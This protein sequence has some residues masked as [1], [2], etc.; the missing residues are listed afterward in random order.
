ML[1]QKGANTQGG[2]FS[3][4]ENNNRGRVDYSNNDNRGRVDY[5]NDQLEIKPAI[6]IDKKNI[7]KSAVHEYNKIGDE[8]EIIKS[9]QPN[10]D[11]DA[12]IHDGNNSSSSSSEEPINTNEEQSRVL[13][14]NELMMHQL[15]DEKFQSE[16]RISDI[17]KKRN[18]NIDDLTNEVIDRT[19]F[20]SKKGVESE[21]HIK[22]L[23]VKVGENCSITTRYVGSEPYLIEIGNHVQI[24]INLLFYLANGI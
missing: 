20:N 11:M 24:T 12:I 1:K 6:N 15:N 14:S 17:N 10:N 23:G 9:Q 3:N 22:K 8:L 13:N 2:G 19:L 5:S 4:P 16:N 18:S 21:K 7:F